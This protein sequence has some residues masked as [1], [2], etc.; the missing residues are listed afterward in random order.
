MITQRTTCIFS[1][2]LSVVDMNNSGLKPEKI[3]KLRK[4]NKLD[5]YNKGIIQP[6]THKMR[7]TSKSGIERVMYTI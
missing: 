5:K 6:Q 4:K 7:Q 3:K 2:E 1:P